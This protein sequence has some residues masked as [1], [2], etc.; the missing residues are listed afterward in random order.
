MWIW[1]HYKIQNWIIYVFLIPWSTWVAELYLCLVI[2]AVSNAGVTSLISDVQCFACCCNLQP[3][4]DA[5]SMKSDELQHV[6][7]CIVMH[8]SVQHGAQSYDWQT[9]VISVWSLICLSSIYVIYLGRHPR[10]TEHGASHSN[11][12]V[13]KGHTSD[14]TNSRWQHNDDSIIGAVNAGAVPQWSWIK[15]TFGCSDRYPLLI[16]WYRY[17]T[18]LSR[19]VINLVH[20]CM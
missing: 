3:S 20:I 2:S 18:K 8:N 9:V 19:F 14:Q 11:D 6:T 5:P 10:S 4:S 16:M 1:F 15:T 13:F 7:F 12:W 17:L